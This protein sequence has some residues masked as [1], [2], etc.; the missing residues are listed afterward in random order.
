MLEAA[1]ESL[2]FMQKDPETSM[3]MSAYTRGVNAYIEQV[4][5]K[6]MP[7]EYKLLDYR[8][9]P[10]SDLKTVLIMK[11]MAAILSGFEEDYSMTNMMMALG[12][13]A[14]NKYFPDFW[15]DISPVVSQKGSGTNPSLAYIK[16]PGYLDFSFL[17]ARSV[18]EK[19]AY[20]PR[21]GSN[22]W[23]VS[24]RKTKSGKP[25]LCSDPHLNLSLPS[26]WIE[27]QLS[28]PGENVYG[29]SIPGTPA[30]II[31]FTDRI[32]WGI[33]N[34]AD[35]VKDWYKLKISDDYK[36]YEFGGRWVDMRC[37]VEEIKRKGQS[38]F[39]DTLYHTIQGPVPYN[40]NFPGPRPELRN[41]ALKWELHNPSNEFL[42][43]IKL[44][45]AAN[46]GEYMEAIGHYSSPIQN[47]T[48]ACS[49]NTIAINHQG[50]MAVK[51]PGQGKFILDGSDPSHLY[52]R[53]IPRDSLP[54]CKNPPCDYVF[55]ANQHPTDNSYSF[56]YNG[57]FNETRAR[58]IQRFLAKGGQFD[59]QAMEQ[60]QLDDMNGFAAAALPVLLKRID[61]TNMVPGVKARLDS[62]SNWNYMY[63]L[64]DKNA[65]LFELWWKNIRDYTWDELRNYSF[66]TELPDDYVLVSLIRDEP[67]NIYFDEQGTTGRENAADIV[68]QAFL[69]AASKYGNMARGGDVRWGSVN[70]VSLMHPTNM[71]LFSRTNLASAGCQDAINAMSPTWGPSWRMI[72]QLGER[73]R[74]FGIYPGG[75]SGNIGSPYYDDF[76]NDW[77]KGQYYP[78]LFCLSMKEAKAHSTTEWELV[79]DNNH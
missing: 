19:S 14:F 53:Y 1:K 70:K 6:Q 26:I 15:G 56:Y 52:S 75:Q 38:M 13:T 63:T 32:A 39:F 58:Q 47:F 24:G 21:L 36:K 12:E 5:Y 9:E 29:V 18:M 67:D 66:N 43:F 35:D 79:P 62:L 44:N 42:C 3:V 40:K 51:W 49:D 46:Y 27:M 30:I 60:M 64:M 37:T 77:N 7:L 50:R 61:T 76:V 74:A 72:V 68:T 25:I 11:Y 23:A 20:N 65:E 55:S 17:A 69:S 31:G 10:W 41:H 4:G 54:F 16:K 22:S 59:V 2:K 28:A 78:L 34:G 45:K 57:Y 73:P 48:F 8:P 33:T 71:E